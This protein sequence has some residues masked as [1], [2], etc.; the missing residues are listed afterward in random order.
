[1]KT[2][3]HVKSELQKYKP[4]L[5]IAINTLP[6]YLTDFDNAVE[7]VFGQSPTMLGGVAEVFEV[8]AYHQILRR[9]TSWPGK[10]GTD[11]KRRS[12]QT[13]VCTIQG[14][15]LYLDG[16]HANRGRA[17]TLSTDEFVELVNGVEQSEAD[18]VCVF[19][20]TDFLEYRNTSDGRRRIERLMHFRA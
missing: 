19:T 4:D 16:M 18:G 13:T 20:F 17:T 9:D 6:F 12:K 15:P 5:Q 14:N 10:I 1:V 7:E 2:V 8:M 3:A 11:I